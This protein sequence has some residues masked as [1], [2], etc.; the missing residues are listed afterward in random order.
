MWTNAALVAG[1]VNTDGHDGCSSIS[2]AGNQLFLFKND[3]AGASRGG[4]IYVSRLSSTGKWSNPKSLAKPINSSYYEDGA[5]ISPNGKTIYFISERPGGFGHA[6]IYTAEKKSGSE[7][8]LPKNI[9][10]EINTPE[11][12]GGLFLAPDG[13]TL[14]FTSKGHGSMGGYDIFKTVN[15][16]GKWSAPVN[17]G[18]PINTVNNDMGFTLSVD[19]QT[20]YFSS[21]RK[22]GLGGRDI[23]KVDLRNYPVLQKEMKAAAVNAGPPMAILR[24]DIFNASNGSAMEAEIIIYDADGKQIAATSSSTEGGEY[25]ITLEANKFYEVK[26][27][28][29]GFKAVDE[30][31]ELKKSKEGPTTVVKHFLLYKTK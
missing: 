26:I 4:D 25:F 23:Y 14:F 18:Y 16:K 15:E 8:D 13:K 28:K 17:L 7:W 30:K 29:P 20:G 11:D 5:C 3:P 24:G 27:N 10:V 1:A 31:F 22:G 19:A 6:D 21:N 2:P 9:G 12:E